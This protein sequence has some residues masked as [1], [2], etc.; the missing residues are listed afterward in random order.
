MD[1]RLKVACLVLIV[2]VSIGLMPDAVSAY[3]FQTWERPGRV[4]VQQVVGSHTLYGGVGGGWGNAPSC[5]LTGCFYGRLTD[6][7]TR[8]Y[9]SP[10]TAG[11]QT[12]TAQYSIAILDTSANAYVP[13]K[14][15]TFRGTIPSGVEW[16]RMTGLDIEPSTDVGHHVYQVT[17]TIWWQ[18]DRG[19]RLGVYRAFMNQS[20]DY[21]CQTIQACN[22]N[23]SPK[24]S[25]IYLPTLSQF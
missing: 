6:A 20:S 22:I 24:G 11:A 13:I 16:I 23:N 4:V 8:V 19:V 3:T 14:T 12:I 1:N 10:A 25:G 2:A 21:S 5:P 17:Q 7:G 9:R 18:T 15:Q